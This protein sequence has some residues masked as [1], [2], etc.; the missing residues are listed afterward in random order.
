MAP[1]R[2]AFSLHSIFRLSVASNSLLYHL[3]TDA[4]SFEKS[5]RIL[6]KIIALASDV[7]GSKKLPT[8]F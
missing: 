6:R 8:E 3:T 1:R 7:L 5:C 4:L 2:V